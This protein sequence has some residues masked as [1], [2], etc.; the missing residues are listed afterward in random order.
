MGVLWRG[1]EGTDHR[2]VVEVCVKVT[3]TGKPS[4]RKTPCRRVR[5][6]SSDIRGNTDV[7]TEEPDVNTLRSPLR[8]VDT[9]SDLVK[10]CAIGP[11]IRDGDAAALIDGLTLGMIVAIASNKIPSEARVVDCAGTRG[12]QGNPIGMR[13]INAFDNIDLAIDRITARA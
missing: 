10:P 2:H 6:T 12:V 13:P 1:K 4:S 3:V 8:G 9:T 5:S 7:T 11:F